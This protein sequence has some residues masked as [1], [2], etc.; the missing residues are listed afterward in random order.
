[1][2]GLLPLLGIWGCVFAQTTD[3]LPLDLARIDTIVPGESTRIEVTGLLGAPDEII[4]S[5]REHDA[6]LERA[7][8]YKRTRSRNTFFTIII[9]STSRKEGQQRPRRGLLR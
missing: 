9:F 1:M 8:I 5:N 6:L 3:G 2:L 4:Y 7:F